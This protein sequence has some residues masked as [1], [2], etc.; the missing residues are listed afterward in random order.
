MFFSYK[1]IKLPLFMYNLYGPIK[2]TRSQNWVICPDISQ[3][4]L[5]T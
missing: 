1:V 5:P 3:S 4:P 2:M